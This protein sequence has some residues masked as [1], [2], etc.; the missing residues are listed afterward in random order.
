VR[1]V[2]GEHGGQ[3]GEIALVLLARRREAR[4]PALAR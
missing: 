2:V 1:H 3:A 4:L